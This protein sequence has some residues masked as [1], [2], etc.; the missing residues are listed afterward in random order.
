M[1]LR[2]M[3]LS[4]TQP[5]SYTKQKRTK[6]QKLNEVVSYCFWAWTLAELEVFGSLTCHDCCYG[7][8]VFAVPNPPELSI[9]PISLGA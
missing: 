3:K 7:K 5:K 9:L 2:E 8:L 4:K 1:K 6:K